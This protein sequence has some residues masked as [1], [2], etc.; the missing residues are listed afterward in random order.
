MEKDQ[1]NEEIEFLRE[2]DDILEESVVETVQE[3]EMAKQREDF[4]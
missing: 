4:S 1:E 2:R 3:D